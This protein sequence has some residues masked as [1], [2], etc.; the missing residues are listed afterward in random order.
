MQSK[1]V[2]ILLP[3]GVGLRNFAFTNFHQLG[4]DNGFDITFW[5]VTPFKLEELGFKELKITNPK[6]HPL[7]DF[8]KKAQ[9]QIELS[10]NIKKSKDKVYDSYRFPFL[11]TNLKERVKAFIVRNIIF[12]NNSQKGLNR[13][14]KKVALNERKTKLYFDSV[15]TL[16]AEK[17]AMVF[18]TNQRMITAVASIL[19]AQDL[20]I[21]TTTFIFS[22]D[23]LPK[24]TKIIET[25][26]YFV[27]SEHMKNELVYYYPY[28][29]EEQI[30]I[31]G[32]PQFET[33]FDKNL[34]LSKDAFCQKNN[35]DSAKK[36]ICFSGDDITTSPNDPQYLLD[37]AKAVRELNAKGNNLG[38]I[39]RRC[40]VDFSDRYD[41]VLET[42]KDIIFPINPEWRNI[43]E[44]WNAIL[45]TKEDLALLMNTIF[46][47]E[48]VINLGS[49]M[50]FDYAVFNKPCGFINYDVVNQKFPDW[51]VRKIYNFI[52]FRSMPIKDSVFWLDN[53]NEIAAKIEMMLSYKS[54]E[55]IMNAQ[56]WFQKINQHPPEKASERI[57][58]AIEKII[59]K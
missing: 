36:Y 9:I 35:L 25:D 10:Q 45:P 19:A 14:R 15:A 16:E 30:F 2:F 47:T 48:L 23:N 4:I 32:T 56:K 20:G 17:P 13:I 22:W 12:F 29:K 34:L 21:P 33:H 26:F 43:G 41:A 37:V 28:I 54:K 6:V 58:N 59:E 3:D 44:N 1:K 11:Q 31:T 7:T 27:W 18:C 50:V 52:H 39:F 40:P 57:W 5:N 8:L 42:L 24:G 51:S 55:I 38:I 53:P 49:S 46:H